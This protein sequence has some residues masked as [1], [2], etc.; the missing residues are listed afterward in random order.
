MQCGHEF[1]LRS[2]G[3]Y[4]RVEKF[5]LSRDD[6]WDSDD[7]LHKLMIFEY[8]NGKWYPWLLEVDGNHV[9]LVTEIARRHGNCRGLI[10]RDVPKGVLSLD[11]LEPCQ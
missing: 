1:K 9:S 5:E 7:S 3:L 8:E 6:W 10:G 4:E 11:G 2:D